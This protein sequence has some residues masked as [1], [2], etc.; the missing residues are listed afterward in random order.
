MMATKV[1][2]NNVFT[3]KP[4]VSKTSSK[5]AE[6]LDS[7]FMSRQQQHL[8]KKRRNVSIFSVFKLDNYD[9]NLIS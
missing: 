6:S 8:E 1:I 4:K 5:I 3:F 9:V 7:D 2:D